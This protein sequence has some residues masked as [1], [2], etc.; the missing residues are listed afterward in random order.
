M[1]IVVNMIGRPVDMHGIELIQ[2]KAQHKS[3]SAMFIATF[4]ILCVERESRQKLIF[5]HFCC[6][7]S[8]AISRKHDAEQ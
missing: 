2:Q 1:E 5:A 3:H 4:S 7:R 6:H 8:T